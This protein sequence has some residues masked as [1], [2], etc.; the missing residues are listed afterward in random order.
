ML[1]MQSVLILTSLVANRAHA[2]TQNFLW[3]EQAFSWTSDSFCSTENCS[4]SVEKVQSYLVYFK[5]QI[6]LI[7]IS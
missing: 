2:T 3:L 5:C 1:V 6:I 4:V 7:Y